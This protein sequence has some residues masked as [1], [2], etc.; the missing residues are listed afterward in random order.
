MLREVYVLIF[1]FILVLGYFSC[2]PIATV[3]HEECTT[4]KPYVFEFPV[5]TEPS[6]TKLSVGDTVSIDFSFSSKAKDATDGK[7]YDLKDFLSFEPEIRLYHIEDSIR[8]P[9]FFEFS[10]TCCTQAKNLFVDHYLPDRDR[11]KDAGIG[12]DFVYV[13]D[14]DIFESKVSFILKKKGIYYFKITSGSIPELTGPFP[15]KCNTRLVYIGFNQQ[16]DGNFDLI[17]SLYV[18]ICKNDASCYEEFKGQFNL[19]GGYA[20]EV[21]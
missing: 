13:P 2:G 18:P 3:I 14:R 19:D 15:G 21:K 6:G 16:S 1:C 11:R 8:N 12:F 5:V 4:A 17:K 10:D 7:I 9:Y 20:F